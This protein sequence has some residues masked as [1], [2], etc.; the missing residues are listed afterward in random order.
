MADVR[1]GLDP[2][3]Y[4]FINLNPDPDFSPERNKS[5]V[6]E[7]IRETDKFLSDLNKI[8]DDKGKQ[9]LDVLSHYAVYTIGKGNTQSLKKYLGKEQYEA[10]IGEKILSKIRVMDNI[11]KVNGNTRFKKGI[12][13]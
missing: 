3:D 9:L 4:R 12:L 13:L 6:E 8:K 2:K 10:L 7:T 11:N 1:S 5:I